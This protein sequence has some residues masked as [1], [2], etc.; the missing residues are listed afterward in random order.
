MQQTTMELLSIF[1]NGDKYT[2]YK[3]G[4]MMAM[5]QKTEILVRDIDIA[6][7]QVIF[8]QP[9]GRKLY[10]LRLEWQPY[11]N[12]PISFFRGAVFA[13]WNQPILCDTEQPRSAG[14]GPFVMRGNACYNFIGAPE[15]I[16][17]WID[18]GQLN[19][20][21][22]KASVVAIDPAKAGT[23]G[24]GPETVVYPELV[25]TGR[26]AVIDGL[27]DRMAERECEYGNGADCNSLP[28]G[29]RRSVC[30][31]CRARAL[32]AGLAENR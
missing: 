28:Q 13:G 12:A 15:Y 5:T 29:V 26:H 10:V 24:D 1:N 3:I 19:P 27:I 21:F 2:I 32:L 6:K 16:R 22:E 11:V 8:S 4:E 25:E 20:L 14:K 23:C 31:P 9:R 18:R 30:W 17:A 7:G